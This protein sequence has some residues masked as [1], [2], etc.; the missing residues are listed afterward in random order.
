MTA[1]RKPKPKA[2]PRFNV[3]V[4]GIVIAVAAVAIP[5]LGKST[6]PVIDYAGIVLVGLGASGLTLATSWGGSTYAWG[7]RGILGLFGG[8]GVDA[9]AARL[10]LSTEKSG[11]LLSYIAAHEVGHTLGL[12]H[13]GSSSTS[14]YAGHGSGDR[15]HPYQCEADHRVE[16]RDRLDVASDHGADEE[17]SEHGPDE[18]VPHAHERGQPTEARLACLA[19]GLA[20]A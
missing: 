11:A 7:S 13:D 19:N 14:Y 1:A 6:R 12:S 16:D 17:C 8:S 10:P 15:H 4:L 20:V 5:A 3:K 18:E 2:T 9:G